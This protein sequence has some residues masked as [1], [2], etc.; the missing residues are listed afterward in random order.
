VFFVSASDWLF[1]QSRHLVAAPYFAEIVRDRGSIFAV[2]GRPYLAAL[3]SPLRLSGL[4]RCCHGRGRR[5]PSGLL[6]RDPTDD[7]FLNWR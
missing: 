5:S 1:Q 3:I 6:R 4:G 7:K 2:L